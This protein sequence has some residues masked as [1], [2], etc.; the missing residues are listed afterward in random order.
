MPALA[1]EIAAIEAESNRPPWSE[2]LILQEFSHQHARV[3]GARLG[4]KLVGF[5]ICHVVQDEAH[6]M[7]FGVA[8]T[9][10]GQGVGRAILA[11]LI[12]ELHTEAVR[13]ITLEVR[14]SNF[15]AR[16]LYE[17]TGFEEVGVR[18]KYYSDNQED[19]LVL[20]LNIGHFVHDLDSSN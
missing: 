19:A 2:Q 16:K 1:A 5:L 9:A 4:G 6:I 20:K 14:R 11:D 15:V 12:R 7:N 18:P 13:W 10:R 17:S 3:L 8:A